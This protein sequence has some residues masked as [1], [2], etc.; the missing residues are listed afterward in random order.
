MSVRIVTLPLL[1]RLQLRIFWQQPSTL[2][3]VDHAAQTSA[4]ELLPRQDYAIWILTLTAHIP[5]VQDHCLVIE[6][7]SGGRRANE[8]EWALTKMDQ[9]S[10]IERAGRRRRS[11]RNHRRKYLRIISHFLFPAPTRMDCS[12]HKGR[13]S[14]LFTVTTRAIRSTWWFVEASV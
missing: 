8:C 6:R 12:L 5:C 13:F 14:P 2:C 9:C 1:L 10:L 3:E 7:R 4:L 11:G